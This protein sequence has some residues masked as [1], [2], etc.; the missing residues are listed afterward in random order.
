M[1][2]GYSQR[3]QGR[4]EGTHRG[5]R[6][7]GRVLTEVAWGEG[8]VLTEVAGEKGGYSQRWQGRREGTHRGGMGTRVTGGALGALDSFP[9]FPAFENNTHTH[10]RT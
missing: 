2:G 6:G 9:F 8:R 1:G 10:I 7:E 5:G 3:W 4:R